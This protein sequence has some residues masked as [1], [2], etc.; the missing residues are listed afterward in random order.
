MQLINK[1]LIIP[2]RVQPYFYLNTRIY[3]NR[4]SDARVMVFE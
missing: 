3:K 1:W 2:A 4:L